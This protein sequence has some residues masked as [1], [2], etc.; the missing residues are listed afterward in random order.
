MT[1]GRREKISM[2]E[3]VTIFWLGALALLCA[4][5]VLP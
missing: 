3:Y 4:L 5:S 2:R 1:G